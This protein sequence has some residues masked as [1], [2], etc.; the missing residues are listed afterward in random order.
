MSH[1]RSEIESLLEPSLG[2]GAG[3][4]YSLRACFFVAFLGG[5]LA[6]LLFSALN[7]RRL[8]RLAR[9]AWVYALGGLVTVAFLVA[10]A[11]VAVEGTPPEWL[12]WIGGDGKR[13][14]RNASRLLALL[15]FGGLYLLHRPFHRAARLRGLDAPSPWVPGIAATLAGGAVTVGLVALLTG[16]S[17][18]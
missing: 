13:G 12:G 5:P 17:G 9:D 14:L 6:I 3:T 1:A 4:I 10:L 18:A 2:S 7:S 11:P 8:G 15:L 16:A